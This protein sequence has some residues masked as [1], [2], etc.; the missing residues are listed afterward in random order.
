MN[1]DEAEGEGEAN[2]GVDD[3]AVVREED[4]AVPKPVGQPICGCR[5]EDQG[6]V[7]RSD[8]LSAGDFML[9][10]RWPCPLLCREQLD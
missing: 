10:D 8:Q 4:A 9:R 2:G 5:C 7:T 6:K 3:M 1:G